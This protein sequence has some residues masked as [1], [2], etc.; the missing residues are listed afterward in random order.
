MAPQQ[1]ITI[2][3]PPAWERST[4]TMLA[5]GQLVADGQLSVF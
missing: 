4:A 2:I 5:L 1:P 3:D